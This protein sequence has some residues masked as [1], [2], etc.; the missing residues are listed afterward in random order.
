RRMKSG[1]ILINTA[2]GPLVDESALAEALRAGHL[3]GAGLD[4]YEK[5]PIVTPGLLDLPNVVLLPHV[6]SATVQTRTRMAMLAARNVR[7][8]LSGEPALTPLR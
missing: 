3:A 1:S 2:R 6:G 7:A 8:V 4:V 5:E